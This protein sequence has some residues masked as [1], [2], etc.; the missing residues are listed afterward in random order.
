MRQIVSFILL[1]AAVSG[2]FFLFRSVIPLVILIIKYPRFTAETGELRRP[3][4]IVSLSFLAAQLLQLQLHR[5]VFNPL[6]NQRHVNLLPAF[7]AGLQTPDC[8]RET[9]R[10]TV[11]RL[12]IS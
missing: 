12:A 3:V 2:R 7:Y 9:D 5:F 6:G 4:K 10:Y 11:A 1:T 8:E